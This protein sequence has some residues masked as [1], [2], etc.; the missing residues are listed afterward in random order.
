MLGIE[1]SSLF[2]IS[3]SF[4]FFI[5]GLWPLEIEGPP[6]SISISNSLLIEVSSGFFNFYIF[7]ISNISGIV[8]FYFCIYARDRCILFIF[9]INS[10]SDSRFIFFYFYIFSISNI[11]GI[12]FFFCFYIFYLY[13][14]YQ[15]EF[16]WNL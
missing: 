14:C 2:S 6:I 1:G 8:F 16:H 5:S 4:S 10:R 3:T 9:Y 15:L 13:L 11:S 12:N 7:A